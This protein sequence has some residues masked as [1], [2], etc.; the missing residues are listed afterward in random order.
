M[1]Q[2]LISMAHYNKWANSRMSEAIAAI[3]EDEYMK[4]RGSFF[5]SIHGTLNH[6]LLV[7]RLWHGRLI[8]NPYPA[9]SLDQVVVEDRDTYINDRTAQDDIIIDYVEG[10]SATEFEE[11]VSYSSLIGF[12]AIDQRRTIIA[13]MFNHAT[14]HR[15]QA[16]DQLSKV[17]MDPPP[18]D[19]MIYLRAIE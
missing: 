6:L 3:P 13:H 1:Q 14:H 5:G 9:D 2:H 16:H 19:Y 18:L 12:S 8:D 10:L 4:E 7:D 11:D 15:G 17:P